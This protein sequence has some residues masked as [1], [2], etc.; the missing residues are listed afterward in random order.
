MTEASS[1]P[2]SSLNF[3]RSLFIRTGGDTKKQVSMHEIG[4]EAGL[5]KP[6]SKNIAEELMRLGLID[7]RTLSGGIGLTAEGVLEAQG[8]FTDITGIGATG[9]TLG[10]HPVVGEKNSAVITD[11]LVNLKPRIGKLDMA[12]DDLT[13]LLAD[14]QSVEAQMRSSRPKTAIVRECFRTMLP[15]HTLSSETEM[16]TRIKS[17]LAD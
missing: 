2:D 4:N 3:F 9:I 13:E 14:I 11:I 5:D 16:L 7:I 10:N 15:T 17:F 6:A 8:W 1:L 12:Y